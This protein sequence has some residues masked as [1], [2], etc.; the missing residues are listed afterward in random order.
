M[1][2]RLPTKIVPLNIGV[3]VATAAECSSDGSLR[4]SIMV[5]QVQLVSS[6]L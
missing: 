5:E 1:N 4:G 3:A 2:F 6:G